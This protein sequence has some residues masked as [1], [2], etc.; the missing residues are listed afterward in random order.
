MTLELRIEN[1]SKTNANG[2]QALDRISLTIPA[3]MY[4]LLGPSGAGKSTLMRTLA[5]L[6]EPD[7]RSDAV[8][9]FPLRSLRLLQSASQIQVAKQAMKV[10]GMNPEI[11]G[12]F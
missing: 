6:Q 10:V 7:S 1:L 8:L 3:G 12:C 11:A 4:G 9:P 5:T 2:I